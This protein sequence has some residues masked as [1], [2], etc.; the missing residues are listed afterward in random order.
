[1]PKYCRARLSKLY[2]IPV[3]RLAFGTS[4]LRQQEVT[5]QID[6]IGRYA[7]EL[8]KAL[9]SLAE[10]NIREFVHDDIAKSPSSRVLVAGAFRK[11]ALVSLAL[12]RTFSRTER[13]LGKTVDILHS[14]DH[15]IPHLRRTP[16]VAT[17]H[18][19]VPLSH[20]EWNAYSFK[21]LKNALWRRSACW[22]DHIITVSEDSKRETVRWFGISPERIN[23]I[24][25]GVGREWFGE[26][27]REELERV[28]KR[29]ALPERFFL[30][31]GTLQPRKNIGR[32]IEAHRSLPATMR[33]DIPL[34]VAGRAG[35]DCQSE[36]DALSSGD[37]GTLRYLGHVPNDDLLPLVK[38]AAVMVQPS[39]HEGFGLPVLEAFA[40]GTPVAASNA[41]AIPEVAGGAA[42]LFDPMDAGDIA[43]TMHSVATDQTFAAVL[44]ARARGRA[45]RFTWD[46]TAELTLKVY[47]SVLARRRND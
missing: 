38:R 43:R 45:K 24:P 26:A 25:L 6:G 9:D 46:R 8:R 21:R 35:W 31:V 15:F 17:I 12:N 7:S 30:F 22:A 1:M 2:D 11:Q 33:R 44:R 5:G 42:A 32:L 18:D 36:V 41:G 39:L 40:A 37:E 47:R 13:A 29:H 23:V 4:V 14:T 28:K 34:V 20:P 19:A 3:L 16:V 10:L 27:P